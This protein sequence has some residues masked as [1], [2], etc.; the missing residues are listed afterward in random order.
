MQS[1]QEHSNQQIERVN[2]KQH[3][4]FN[5]KT[6]WYCVRT[7]IGHTPTNQTDTRG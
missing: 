1:K 5:R 6:M 7:T 3:N 4:H 2:G